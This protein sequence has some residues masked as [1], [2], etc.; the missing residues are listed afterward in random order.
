[1]DCPGDDELIRLYCEGDGDA[2]EALFDRHYVSVFNFARV[3]LRDAEAA[4]EVLQDTFLAAAR[5]APQYRG[6]GRF[7]AW[8]LAIARNRCLTRLIAEKA[9]T[10]RLTRVDLALEDSPAP[11]D[12]PPQ[13]LQASET[14]EAIRAAIG[15]LSDRQREAIALYAFEQMSCAQIAEVLDVPVNTVKTLIHRARASLARMIKGDD[16]GL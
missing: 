8:L 4:E 15:R 3:M 11:G 12:L 13:Q 10:A 6:A 5:A 14:A 9:R 7:K 2:L 1:M 16:R